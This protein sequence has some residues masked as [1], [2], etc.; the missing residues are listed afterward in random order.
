MPIGFAMADSQTPDTSIHN[1]VLYPFTGDL[2]QLRERRVIRVLVSFTKTNFFS[3]PKGFRGIEHDLLR[4]YEQY[5]NRGPRKQRYQTHLTFIP[6]PFS[7]ILTK[8]EKGYGDIAAAG[9]TVTPAKQLLVD[10][11]KPYITNVDKILVSHKNAPQVNNIEDLA[12]KKIAVVAKSSQVI[13]LQLINLAL[14][15][16]G[17]QPIEVYQANPLLELEDLLKLV[18][19]GIYDF[20]V[21]DD[22]I[23]SIWQNLLPNIQLHHH[24]VFQNNTN[25]AWAIQKDLPKLKKSLNGFIH[26]KAQPGRLL[27]NMVYTRYFENYF[28][29]KKPLTHNLLKDNKCLQHY[30][31]FYGEFYDINWLLIA[32]LAYQ[33][34]RFKQHKKSHAGAVGIM[35]IKPTTASYKNVDVADI[36]ILEN[37]IH[38]GVRYLAFLKENYFASD[39]YTAEEQINFALAA[40]NAGPSRVLGLKRE[41]KRRGLN[42]YIWFYNVEIIARERIGH[43]TVNYV[44]DIQKMKLFLQAS[45]KVKTNRLNFI[46]EIMAENGESATGSS[47]PQKIYGR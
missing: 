12:G 25:I 6:V 18:N 2:D 20:T 4:A 31:E 9:L 29:L 14:G 36:H 39:N 27:G 23:A 13:Y 45:K 3:T 21:I 44:A 42:P 41:A 5:L 24:I 34:S 47:D 10:F 43:E 11:T 1:R 40:Y 16:Q 32:A 15:M 17:L 8:L 28:W 35:Q 46:A 7:Q 19:E 33:E 26:N 37:N 30:F 38:A 22:H